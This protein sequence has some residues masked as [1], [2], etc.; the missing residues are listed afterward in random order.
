MQVQIWT[1]EA[2][3]DCLAS[4]IWGIPTQV[5]V[6]MDTCVSAAAGQC[7]EVWYGVAWSGRDLVATAA[8]PTHD[9]AMVAVRRCVG[10]SVPI[11][12]LSEMPR[13]VADI[14]QMLGDLEAGHEEGKHFTLSTEFVSPPMR[15]IL[16]VAA[17]IPIGYVTTYGHVARAAKSEARPV[18]R[19]MATNP[20]YPIVPCH[21]VLGADLRPVGY[22]GK[23]DEVALTD[24]MGRISNE[25]RGYRQ[26]HTIDVEQ[27]T[28]ILYPGEW[29]IQA[30]A[31]EENRLRREAD[32]QE[33][34]DAAEREQLRLF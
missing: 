16:T 21:R 1:A 25:L 6:T 12:T 9:E 29:A 31:A 10:R 2:T 23:Q 34:T 27:G 14:V 3:V 15:S 5:T 22:G 24:K 28:L 30:A 11:Q 4:Y 7:G 26:E 20:L 32:H 13:F 33:R 8:G 18:G 17:A 19:A